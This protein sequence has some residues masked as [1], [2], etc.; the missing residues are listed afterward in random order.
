MTI[1]NLLD[2]KG[3]GAIDAQMLKKMGEIL[4]EDEDLEAIAKWLHYDFTQ[5]SHISQFLEMAQEMKEWGIYQADIN[6]EDSY[7]DELI[8]KGYYSDLSY[9]AWDKNIM[10]FFNADY[11]E[12]LIN[13]FFENNSEFLLGEWQSKNCYNL[14]SIILLTTRRYIEWALNEALEKELE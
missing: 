8:K 10:E 1:K 6:L 14:T 3:L 11:N 9:G 7:Y 13:E 5:P 12:D 2:K 4:A